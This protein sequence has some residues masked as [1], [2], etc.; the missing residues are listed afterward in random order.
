M[1]RFNAPMKPKAGVRVVTNLAGGDA[2]DRTPRLSLVSMVL[3]S[4][5]QDSFYQSAEAQVE[6]VAAL[7]RKLAEQDDLLFAAKL[8]VYV[9]N[10]HGLRSISHVVAGEVAKMRDEFPT[11]K[12]LLDPN[13]S[14]NW[15]GDF[16]QRLAFRPDDMLE[17]AGYWITKYGNGEKKTLPAAM[18]R[19]FSAAFA[20]FKPETLAKYNGA[21]TKSMTL[22]QLAHLVHPAGPKDSTLYK[23]R[24]GTL[25]TADTFEVALSRAGNEENAEEAK[26][27]EWGRLLNAG[28]IGY[29]AGLRNIRNVLQQA[30]ESAEKLFEVLLDD[31]QIAKSKVFPFQFMAAFDAITTCQPPP[32]RAARALEV[33]EQ[34][35][36][37]A[38][39]NVPVLSG[40]TLVAL[41][42]SGSMLHPRN[43]SRGNKLV[44]TPQ[45]K[46]PG[47]FGA[48]FGTALYLSG[49]DVDLMLFSDTAH[50]VTLMPSA[51]LFAGVQKLLANA[52]P[53]GTNFHAPFQTAGRAYD[54]IIILS[55]EQGWVH[56]GGMSRPVPSIDEYKR[57]FN[58]NP[59][60]YTWNLVGSETSMFPERRTYSLAGVSDKVFDLLAALETDPQAMLSAIEKT[61]ITR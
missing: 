40:S 42:E 44:M 61:Q 14:F 57:K 2:F 21:S 23:L 17:I 7:V 54:R 24:G 4:M 11:H 30:P 43:E 28:K 36:R 47:V 58:A 50:Y 27:Q 10:E 12:N 32:P 34:A 5:V 60:I 19:G 51:G 1:A 16:F 37:K 15:G 22:R 20:R 45:H 38:L 49:A 46:L 18:K 48:V 31:E 39:K 13:T 53:A 6:T 41:D 56:E 59:R 8:A 3:T 9:R 35:S 26:G 52:K 55:D 33:I 29:L 25:P